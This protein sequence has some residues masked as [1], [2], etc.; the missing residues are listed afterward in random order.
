M[1]FLVFI[2]QLSV[3]Q[4]EASWALHASVGWGEHEE[5]P[6]PMGIFQIRKGEA[7]VGA[8][9]RWGVCVLYNRKKKATLNPG[10][11]SKRL[12]KP[13]RKI[14]DQ[15]ERIGEQIFCGERKFGEIREETAKTH[16]L[17]L[18]TKN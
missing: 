18:K 6:P 10:L 12:Q 14:P 11:S 4:S 16:R 2:A 8:A 13:D 1:H 5:V 9:K 17:F 15:F 7:A 3:S